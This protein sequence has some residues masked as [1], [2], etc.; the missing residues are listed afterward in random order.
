M[1]GEPNMKTN[2]EARWLNH[3]K[4]LTSLFA[5]IVI[6]A[7]LIAG[8]VVTSVYP[9]YQAKDVS[10]DD[11]LLGKWIPADATNASTAEE[12]WTF[13]KINDRTYKLT[14]VENKTNLYDVVRFKLG[15]ARFLDCLT[16][17]RSEI[18]TPSH[19][20][21]RTEI[22]ASQ[23]K[24]ELLDYKWLGNLIEK[25]P[26][27]IRHIIVPDEAQAEKGSGGGLVLTADTA[28]LQKFILKHLKTKDAWVEPLVMKH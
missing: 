8:C 23:L 13:E 22:V 1:T 18:Q 6:V 3:H 26:R 11:T 9:Y 12:F 21:L 24:M 20:L 2:N 25:N 4:K 28:E 27:A 16:R 19:I 15:G 7:S 17:E 14:T 5:G 10:F